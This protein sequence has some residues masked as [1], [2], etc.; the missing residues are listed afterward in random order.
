MQWKKEIGGNLQST[1][2]LLVTICFLMGALALITNKG[3]LFLVVGVGFAFVFLSKMYDKYIG[4][5]ITLG[6]KRRTYR[7]FPGDD[8][9]ITL[10]LKNASWMPIFNGKLQFYAGQVIQN[11]QFYSV[12]HKK[13]NLY[14][15]PIS[16]INKGDASV[17]VNMKAEKR[18]VTRLNGLEYH[19]PHLLSFENITLVL[20]DFYRTEV[21]VYPT[22]IPVK[23]LEERF[24]I[25]IGAQRTTFSP[26]EDQLSP[27]GTRDYLPSDPFHRINWKASAR[28]QSLQTKV[29]ERV[30]D[31]TWVFVV[32][33][34]ESTRLRNTYVSQNIE[35]LLS[36]VT[37]MCQFAAEKG[38]AY[39]IHIN[40]RKAGSPPYFYLHEGEGKEH[41]RWALEFLARVNTEELILPYE[42]LL[43]RVDQ[44]LFKPKT[45]FL[46]G[47]VTP[48]AEMYARQWEKKRMNVYHIEEQ[49]GIAYVGD[50]VREVAAQ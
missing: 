8:V 27:M 43:Y 17:N 20:R 38:Y 3:H 49:D 9:D 39:E 42:N 24:H 45:L 4:H 31:I 2:D 33:I 28:T 18:G 5:G 35:N 30:H 26:F 6:N 36:Y 16:I 50:V 29:Y 19:F 32:N 46:F 44:D 22:P 34:S 25:T 47:E 14:E 13:V 10:R 41:L 37:F 1:Y 48:E 23:G 7:M 15:I 12:G 40:A 21:I 11:E